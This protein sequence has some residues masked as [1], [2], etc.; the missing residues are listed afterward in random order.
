L[1]SRSKSYCCI[2]QAQLKLYLSKDIT[3]QNASIFLVSP[4]IYKLKW[5]IH[6]FTS[7]FCHMGFFTGSRKL[8]TSRIQAQKI[9]KNEK[10]PLQIFE[11][12][13]RE[14]WYQFSLALY[15]NSQWKEFLKECR[16]NNSKCY[17]ASKYLKNLNQV[18][19]SNRSV[20]IAKSRRVVE[21]HLPVCRIISV[22]TSGTKLW[23]NMAVFEIFLL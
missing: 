4:G 23:K 18:S 11:N 1:I 20:K 12:C 19:Q 9:M 13:G 22:F 15:W 14:T 5:I 2:P 10:I 17:S 16:S 8:L 21:S 6:R 3:R 7:D